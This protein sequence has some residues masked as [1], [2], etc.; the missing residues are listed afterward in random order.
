MGRRLG[1]ERRGWVEGH[2]RSTENRGGKGGHGR[3]DLGFC[4]KMVN[5]TYLHTAGGCA[6]GGV[7]DTL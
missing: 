4:V 3:E 5:G 1:G 6:E 2:G 7:L